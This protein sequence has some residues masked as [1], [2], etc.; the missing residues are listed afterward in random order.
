MK[1]SW[2][3]LL[4]IVILAACGPASDP[5]AI[6]SSTWT[7]EPV[8]AV[9][10]PV[11]TANL[12]ASATH[13]QPPTATFTPSVTPSLTLTPSLTWTPSPTMPP[14]ETPSPTITPT[15][16]QVDHYK[17]SRPIARDNN[18]VDWVDR[19][20]P[21]GGTQ[22]DTREVHL[23]VEFVNPR[24]TP[25]LAAASGVVVFAGPD[26]DILIGPSLDYYGNVVVV[27]HD[28][29]S[30]EGLPVYTLYGH[31]QRTEVETGA[32]VTVGDQLGVIGD[33]GIA[34]GPHLHFE[35]RVGTSPFDY[36]LTR[37][38]ELWLQP[39]REFGTLAGRVT[40]PAGEILYGVTLLVRSAEIQ[41]E[42]YTYGSD[43]VN[44]DPVWN[45][46]FTLGD[47]PEGSYEVI[48][49]AENGRRLFRQTVTISAGQTTWLAIVLEKN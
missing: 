38:P 22:F 21:Y 48:I 11:P 20:Y 32:S 43:R 45:E 27:E 14:T 47:L 30:P 37:N 8:A 3:L 15:L 29:L 12:L 24:F 17:L 25:I 6:P 5:T 19:T 49:N 2:T 16:E 33:T 36:T 39:F 4:I 34:I 46:T 13:T 40:N 9:F 35:V 28:F 42:T 10:T 26:S 23:G 7:P 44:S 18:R 1:T 31:M 41:R